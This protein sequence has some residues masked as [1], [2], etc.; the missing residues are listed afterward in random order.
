MESY[1]ISDIY[2]L[3]TPDGKI[4]AYQRKSDR[5]AIAEVRIEGISRAFRGFY[6]PSTMVFFNIKSTLAQIGLDGIGIDYEIDHKTM[7]ARIKVALHARSFLAAKMLEYLQEG[8]CIGKLFAA[9]PNRKVKDPDYLTRMF[10]RM[11]RLGRPLLFLGDPENSLDLT[12]EKIDGRTVAFLN[13]LPGTLCYDASMEG[14]LPTLGLALKEPKC[15]VRHILKLHQQWKKENKREGKAD[16]I[17]LVKTQPLHIRTAFGRVVNELLPKGYVHTSASILEP[18]TSASG[19][20]YELFGQSTSAINIIPLEFFTLEPHREHVFFSDKDQLQNDLKKPEVVF[21]A[22]DTAPKPEHHKCAVFIMKGEQ[23]RNLKVQDWI[24]RQPHQHEFPGLIYDPER[25]AHMVDRYIQQQPSYPFLKAIQD[26][27]ITSQGLLFSRHFPSPLLKKMLLADQIQSSLKG[28]YFQKPSFTGADFFSHEDR[29]MLHDLAK[30][31]IPT[32]WVDEVTQKI[33]EYVPKPDKDTGMFVP[34][35]LVEPFIK[36]SSFGVYGSHK[37]P[38]NFETELTLLLEGLEAMKKEVNHALLNEST[39]I[40]LITGGGA[41]VMELANKIA[42]KLKLL[43]CANIV[44]FTHKD[45]S[46][47]EEQM[48]NPYIDIKMTYRLDRL[49]ERQA[50]FNLDFPIFL[51]G[52]IGTD[53]EYSLEEVRRKVGST[54]ATPVLLFGPV[55]YWKAKVSSRFQC[56]LESGTITGSEWVSNCFFCIQNAHQGLKIYRKFFSGNL[57]IGPRGPVY[58][59]GFVIV[60]N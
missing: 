3:I 49:V 46:V 18:D 54:T 37:T 11:D 51:E 38:G 28:I 17:L 1:L 40:A 9:D 57:E 25:Q 52:G 29:S 34:L 2:D 15:Q 44:D 20:V 45:N 41:G 14:F 36:S 33:L 22:F 58:N 60:K 12:L 59:D 6:I 48:Q 24:T 4:T 16:D 13:L 53:F 27:L 7:T 39:P 35:H 26:G 31:A 55:D 42:R 32:Y 10:N 30:F 50:E 19:D 43:S 5:E 47:F 23:L 21:Q 56:N 8:S